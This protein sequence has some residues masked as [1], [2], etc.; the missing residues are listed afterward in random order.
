MATA[1]LLMSVTDVGLLRGELAQR[2]QH[3]GG[4]QRRLRE[5]AGDVPVALAL[6]C[7]ALAVRPTPTTIEPAREQLGGERLAESA[8]D[9]RD[10]RCV[11]RPPRASDRAASAS[12]RSTVSTVSRLPAND[13]TMTTTTMIASTRSAIFHGLFGYS[14]RIAP[15]HAVHH[16]LER[17]RAV[18]VRQEPD[19]RED[20]L[21]RLARIVGAH[22]AGC[23][24]CRPEP[25][26]R[27]APA[28]SR[29]SR[30][31]RAARRRRG[32]SGSARRPSP[33]RSPR[34]TAC[35]SCVGNGSMPRRSSG[36]TPTDAH[37]RSSSK[38]C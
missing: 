16:A 15:V 26:A 13:S 33:R 28:S 2:G 21:E 22:D 23:G 9:T 17:A 10:D 25:A 35:S 5:I 30:R 6:R 19:R 4:E 29:P 8:R 3:R 14:P 1:A 12:Q 38:K 32:R 20:V 37:T 27:T 18:R 11:H 24:T 31:A 34:R 36:C 7:R